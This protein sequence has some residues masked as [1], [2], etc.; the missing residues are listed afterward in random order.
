[1]KYF[2]TC[3]FGILLSNLFF[4]N[5][6][7]AQANT[8]S[9]EKEVLILSIENSGIPRNPTT[10]NQ[11]RTSLEEKLL[12]Q[13]YKVE[14]LQDSDIESAI[15]QAKKRN[16]HLVLKLSYGRSGFTGNLN[17][18][19]IAFHPETRKIIDSYSLDDELFQFEG[20]KLD[21][22]ELTEK[23]DLRI[24]RFAARVAVSLRSNPGRRERKENIEVLASS[25]ADQSAYKTFLPNSG[26]KEDL[27]SVFDLLQSQVTV[28]TTKTAKKVNEAPGIV[29]VITSKQVEDFGR[30][31]INDV[32]YQLPGFSPGQV[33]ERRTVN[34]RGLF[35]GY[36]N[37]HILTLIDGVQ[38]NDVFYGFA[39]TWEITPLNMVKSLEVIRGPGSALYG[40]N[41]TNGVVSINTFNGRDLKGGIHA[42]AR[43]G[44]FGTQIFDVLTGNQGELFSHIVSYNS[45]QTNGVEF[46]N[47]DGSLRTDEFG[48]LETFSM[49][50][51]RNN[52]Y[53]LT[54][55][56]GEGSLE[57]L[58]IQYHRQQWSYQSFDGWLF[59]NPADSDRM[60]ERRDT[61]I[62]KY[63]SP[64]TEKLVQEYVLKYGTHNWDLN[65]SL[66]PAGNQNFP[67]GLKERIQTSLDSLFLRGQWTYLFENKGSF[68][69]GVEGTRIS[70][71]GD[72]L[73]EANADI[74]ILG[75]QTNFPDN[76]PR[77]LNPFME[78]IENRP[79]DKIATFA[80]LV[81]GK[82]FQK[83]IE[84]TL[85]VRYDESKVRFRGIDRPY[86]D[87]IPNPTID[88]FDPETGGILTEEV[89]NEFLGPPFVPNEKLVFRRTSPRFATTIFFTERFIMK[90]MIGQAFREP[91]PAELMGVNT[92][93]GGSENPR[94][95]R[96]E[97]ITTG[98]FGLDWAPNP[99]L[100]IRVN[101]FQTKFENIIDYSLTNNIITNLYSLGQRG[102]EAEVLY[103]FRYFN[104]FVNYSKFVRFYDSSF[105]P[106]YVSQPREIVN[107]PASRG[108]VGIAA[109][110]WGFFGS[111]SV[112]RQ[113]RVERRKTDLGPVDPITGLA[114]LEGS[115]SDP[116]SF[117]KYRELRTPA[118][119]NTNLRF[120]YK[121]S[122]SMKLSLNVYN[123]ENRIQ[124]LNQTG[125]QPYDYI[126]EGRRVLL[127]FQANL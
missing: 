53:L 101:G 24:R 35:E 60:Q 84:F 75:T 17:L 77:P 51:R 21:P 99:N 48:F 70:Y 5:D 47:Y 27:D 107:S 87:F 86:Q 4:G 46:E 116:Y 62:A 103:Q 125:I 119:T 126:R 50:D 34:S 105:D 36:N 93:I 38:M 59:F 58:S 69:F 73:H 81:S 79:I 90:L 92:F 98:E 80:Q 88:V 120:G 15:S 112:E 110:R 9:S 33:N 118:W 95:L 54:K 122:E 26:E 106:A 16:S 43:V 52:Y 12:S 82:L 61:F 109:E 18:K 55:L 108:N 127:D 91:A 100:N 10:E 72:R 74:N 71:S 66:F 68:V 102:V 25:P 115:F 49:K 39:P 94:N 41:A 30:I 45:F 89:P 23:D 56:E 97:V 29:S 67:F 8:L 123:A 19:M 96:P 20:L 42:R 104:G 1:V 57:G 83:T 64:I 22:S 63:T 7:L 124:Y 14:F 28:S 78:W 37:N 6:S 113:G 111:I 32:L 121:F 117:P 3:F 11:I 114:E 31:S 44:D 13:N 40:S 76:I 85:G 65:S 2:Y